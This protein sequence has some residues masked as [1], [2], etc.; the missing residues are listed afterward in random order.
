ML[1]WNAFF[2]GLVSRLGVAAPSRILSASVFLPLPP[3]CCTHCCYHLPPLPP[4]N[5]A[6]QGV[7]NEIDLIAASFVRKGIDLDYIRQVGMSAGGR[8]WVQAVVGAGC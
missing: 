7:P 8:V 6:L 3:H 2:V 4:T 5:C 1:I